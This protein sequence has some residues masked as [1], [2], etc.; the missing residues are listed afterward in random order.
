MNR[1]LDRVNARDRLAKVAGELEIGRRL[2]QVSERLAV[3]ADTLALVY[4]LSRDALS[5]ALSTGREEGR[6]W[7][8]WARRVH[9]AQTRARTWVESTAR[10]VLYIVQV[11]AVR[12]WAWRVARERHLIPARKVPDNKCNKPLLIQQ[13]QTIID[14]TDSTDLQEVSDSIDD[15]SEAVQKA[16]GVTVRAACESV[17]RKFQHR[18]PWIYKGMTAPESIYRSSD[19]R[20]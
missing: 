2:E 4:T 10:E 3:G 13:I 15:I 5:S 7:I 12:E 8:E 14:R 9:L 16:T 6:I 19:I 20:V 1:M 17:V 11:E 18:L